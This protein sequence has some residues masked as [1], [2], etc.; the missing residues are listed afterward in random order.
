[1]DRTLA[2]ATGR[3]LVAGVVGGR[4]IGVL[5]LVEPSSGVSAEAAR[6]LVESLGDVV[7]VLAEADPKLK[8]QLYEE[9]GVSVTSYHK[10][11]TATACATVRVG[12]ATHSVTTRQPQQPWHFEC[13]A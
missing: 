6:E 12:G 13:E 9:L 2:V 8:A 5:R 7:S 10:T 3:S 4:L 11:R 1:M